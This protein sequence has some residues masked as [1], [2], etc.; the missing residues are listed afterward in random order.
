MVAVN[1]ILS[2]DRRTDELKECRTQ[3]DQGKEMSSSMK[4]HTVSFPQ[5]E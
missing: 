2:L 4:S 3:G 1:A 5:K